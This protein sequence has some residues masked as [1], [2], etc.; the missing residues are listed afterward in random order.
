MEELAGFTVDTRDL[1]GRG[2]FGEVFVAF[3][4]NAERVAAKRIWLKTTNLSDILAE[5]K[6]LKNVKPHKNILKYITSERSKD[7]LWIFTE[8]CEE[9]DLSQYCA[10]H[11]LEFTH[12]LIIAYQ[13]ACAVCHLHGLT[14]TVVHRDI[15]P[16]NIL[17]AHVNGK[18]EI[19]L[20]DFGLAKTAGRDV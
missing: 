1:L 16:N 14:P 4:Q 11:E 18:I 13:C 7:F 8:Y 2:G 5:V 6:T 9:G 10:T 20:A 17:M 3:N 15:K 12:K 19:K